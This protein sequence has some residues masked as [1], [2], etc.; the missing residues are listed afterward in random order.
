M[1]TMPTGATQKVPSPVV[2]EIPM[3]VTQKVPSPLVGEMPGVTQQVPSPLA[4]EGQGE[5]GARVE[6]ARESVV[7]FFHSGWRQG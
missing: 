2:G 1:D 3:G 5:G 4:G 7:G 6:Q